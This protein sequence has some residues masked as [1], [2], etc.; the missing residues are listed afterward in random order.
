VVP[1][2]AFY[3]DF[4][5][6]IWTKYSGNPVMV[7]SQP[8]AESYCI[9]EPNVLY[10]DGLFRMW[11]S[12][13]Y[14]VDYN[15]ALGYATSPDG[16]TW[17]KHP[18]NPVLMREHGQVHRP[19]VMKHQGIYYCF[20][21]QDEQGSRGPATM[22]RW[23]SPDG[24][25]WGDERLVMTAT[26]PWENRTLS[27]M[28]V[29]VDSDGVWRML[30][31]GYATGATK[32]TGGSFGYAYSPDG[33][34]W[35]KYEG[36]PVIAGF[37]GGDPFLLKIGD[38]YYTWHSQAMGGSLR[39]CCRWSTDMIHWHP[40]GNGPQINYT[41]PWERGIPAEDGGHPSGHYGHLSDATLCEAE[42]RV[43]LIYQ[44]AQT[45]LGV[46][47]FEGTF[48]QLADRLSEP[49]LS[50]WKASPYGMVDEA[51]LKIADNGSDREP[52]VAQVPGVRDQY[53]VE[54][55]IRCYAGPTHRVSMVMRCDGKGSFARF[56]LHD[57][58]HTYYQEC[59]TIDP[60]PLFSM[61]VNIGA[62]HACDA[63]WHEWVVEVDHERNRLSIDGR[64]VGECATSR[65][66]LHKCAAEP[67]HV[68][69][70]VFDTF[71]AIDYVRV[72][73]T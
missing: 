52:L 71:A 46:A 26:Q 45:P 60:Y 25:T 27:N 17:T 35:T 5:D 43:F 39:I 42:G 44:G 1:V 38:R 72:R 36:N 2:P 34:T 15:T 6:G 4:S 56:W 65:A 59:I 64:K 8:W 49:P 7:R 18:G 21:V 12:Q 53:V 33:L 48:Q 62:N 58:E 20:A 63:A 28:G 73:R 57:A 41:Q 30:Y 9:C 32:E 55:R 69:F 16:F 37:E 14:P 3:D 68:G 61:P 23:T 29:I 50:R 22:R 10:E 51:T 47:T 40:I 13:M 66:L 54:S 24:I 31:T 11:F 19:H 67:V 70:S